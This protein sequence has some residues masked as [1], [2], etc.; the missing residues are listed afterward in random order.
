[1]NFWKTNADFD[2]A[3]AG[4][5]SALQ[6]PRLADYLISYDCMTDNAHRGSGGSG[7]YATESY[8]TGLLNPST[9]GHVQDIYSQAYAAIARIN[10]FLSQLNVSKNTGMTVDQKKNKIAE[11]HFLRG[12]CYWML[13]M[14]YGEVPLVTE[15]LTIE[16]HIQPK[17]TRSEVY[18]QVIG[19]LQMAIDNFTADQTY[20]GS[21]GRATKSA[22]R[23][24]KARAIMFNAFDASGTAN[25]LEVKKAYDELSQISGYSLNPEYAFNFYNT[26]QEKSPEIIFSVKY[27][28]PGSA[29]DID[30]LFG[31]DNG[32]I[33]T[34]DLYNAY[35]PG[36][37]RRLKTFAEGRT[38]TW[39]G[40]LTVTFPKSANDYN[41]RRPI[42][43]LTPLPLPTGETTWGKLN[44][45]DYDPVILRW[46]ELMLLKAEAATELE[47]L[48]EAKALVDAIRDRQTTIPHLPVGLSK[49]QMRDS[50][51][52]ERRV[53]TATESALRYYDL[54]RWRTMETA[55][56]RA[57]DKDPNFKINVTWTASKNFDLPLPQSEID[58][59]RGVLVQNPGYTN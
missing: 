15:P 38:Y 18:A 32:L 6:A 55:L 58:K 10:I 48:D 5:Y 52:H 54:K 49:V 28:A 17:G 23:G 43:G 46:G 56:H 59:S 21:G 40:K 26:E 35:Y 34:T 41:Y 53:E 47:K 33:P 1:L 3:L 20:R 44:P 42:K 27:L 25:L 2:K 50:V 12:Y 36:D 57:W 37:T 19:D 7:G 8:V 51:R 16:N 4:C 39:V 45:G 9:E 29:H 31:F 22:A 11:A 24:L 13:Y 14:F 30:R